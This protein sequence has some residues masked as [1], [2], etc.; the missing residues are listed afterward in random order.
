MTYTLF[1]FWHS[2][3]PIKSCANIFFV[4]LISRVFHPITYFLSPPPLP[5]ANACICSHAQAHTSV[6][7]YL[8]WVS[9]TS[10]G[11]DRMSMI[12]NYFFQDGLGFH[13]IALSLFLLFQIFIICG[14]KNIS[15]KQSKEGPFT[16]LHNYGWSST[17]MA[18]SHLLSISFD[19]FSMNT[20]FYLLLERLKFLWFSIVENTTNLLPS[21]WRKI[22][23]SWFYLYTL[24]C[25]AMT[26]DSGLSTQNKHSLFSSFSLSSLVRM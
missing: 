15:W 14:I 21:G 22:P 2:C 13:C 6:L 18:C 24:N 26:P 20:Y 8:C 9:L 5:S 3:H 1:L 4:N 12:W 25:K 16:I 7:S 23:R 19:S 11:S 10:S 17:S